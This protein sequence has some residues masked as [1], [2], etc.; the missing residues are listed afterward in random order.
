MTD[1]RQALL[2][3]SLSQCQISLD[4]RLTIPRT[5]GTYDLGAS[6]GGRRFRYGNHPIRMTELLREQGE[7]S[8]VALF[9]AQQDAS[10]LA[11]LLNSMPPTRSRT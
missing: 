7:C 3:R 1:E 6:A 9:Y 8:L 10:R 11:A 4:G 2:E 5:W